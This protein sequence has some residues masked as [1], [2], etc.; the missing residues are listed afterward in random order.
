MLGAS[1]ATL[2]V[3]AG[4]QGKV[5]LI[6]VLKNGFDSLGNFACSGLPAD[7]TCSFAGATATPSGEAATGQLIIRQQAI[8]CPEQGARLSSR[9][10]A[11]AV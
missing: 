4:G 9:F 8:F 11:L 5:M 6:V 7:A 10:T 3:N 2:T 1:E